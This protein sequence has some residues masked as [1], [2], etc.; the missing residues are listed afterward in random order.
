M[1]PV[2]GAFCTLLTSDEA[3]AAFG[4]PLELTG[5]SGKS[6][7]WT[8]VG[9]SMMDASLVPSL[10]DGTLADNKTYYKDF[11]GGIKDITVGGQPGLLRLTT[12]P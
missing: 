6:C 8:P 7:S 5:I 9:K 4:V 11:P 1:T 12:D 2:P 10:F 3:S